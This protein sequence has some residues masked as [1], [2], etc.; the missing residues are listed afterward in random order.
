[1]HK[2]K[3]TVDYKSLTILCNHIIM[4]KKRTLSSTP[5]LVV[6]RMMNK[7]P[8]LEKKRLLMGGKMTS[9]PIRICAV[10]HQIFLEVSN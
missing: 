1:M 4:N 6:K 5:N 7:L 8:K 3:F 2:T 10:Q 9:Y